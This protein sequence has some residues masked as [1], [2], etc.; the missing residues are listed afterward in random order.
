MA[1]LSYIILGQLHYLDNLFDLM[2]PKIY[3]K[4]TRSQPL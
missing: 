2:L 1:V 4:Q 3:E